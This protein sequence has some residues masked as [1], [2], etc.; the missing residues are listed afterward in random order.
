MAELR[1]NCCGKHHVPDYSLKKAFLDNTILTYVKRYTHELAITFVI[2]LC[3]STGTPASWITHLSKFSP[4]LHYWLGKDNSY[5]SSIC[6]SMYLPMYL[7]MYLYIYV[8]MHLSSHFYYFWAM[9]WLFSWIDLELLCIT[10]GELVKIT[11]HQYANCQDYKYKNL[12]SATASDVNISTLR[13][14]SLVT[15]IIVLMEIYK[16]NLILFRDHFWNK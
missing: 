11:L 7:S 10:I 16:I 6:L 3:V 5:L 1:S 15:L 2:V 8:S 12:P 4:L 14:Y 9:D 13:R